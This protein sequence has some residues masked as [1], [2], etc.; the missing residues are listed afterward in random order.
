M[1]LLKGMTMTSHGSGYM[2]LIMGHDGPKP[3]IFLGMPFAWRVYRAKENKMFELK[4][5]SAWDCGTS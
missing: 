5:H 2:V 3:V 4:T 1:G